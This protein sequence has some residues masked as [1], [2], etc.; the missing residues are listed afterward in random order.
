MYFWHGLS[1]EIYFHVTYM[2]GLGKI[3]FR[4]NIIV[5]IG[6]SPAPVTECEAITRN[7]N[8][9]ESSSIRWNY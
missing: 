1:R 8:V 7:S 9:I 5:V 2:Y 6:H 4:V 3:Y